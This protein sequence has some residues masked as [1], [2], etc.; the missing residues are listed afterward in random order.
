MVEAAVVLVEEHQEEEDL[1][2]EVRPEVVELQEVVAV[3]VVV[4]PE[5]EAALVAEAEDVVSID[6]SLYDPKFCECVH[7]AFRQ[8]P[9]GMVG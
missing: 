7:E 5:V 1:H 4:H 2:P 3:L 9:K 6:Q 8:I